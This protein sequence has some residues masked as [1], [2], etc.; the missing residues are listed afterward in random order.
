L[1]KGVI[2]DLGETLMHLNVTWEQVREWR[3]QAIHNALTEQGADPS[4]AEIRRE[5]LQLHEEESDYAART[6]E[7]IEIQESFLKLFERLKVK[8]EQRPNMNE[9]V[10]RFFSLE[11]ESWVIFSGVPEMLQQ[12]R[13]LGLK[14]GLLSNAR[15]DWAVK[16]IMNRLS[17]TPYFDAILTSAALGIRKPRP[18]PF[19]EM[20]KLLGVGATEAVMVGNSVEAD[21]AGARPLGIRSIRVK[22]GDHPD[23]LPLQLE[24]SVDPDATA[25]AVDDIVPA[26]K[27]M[28]TIG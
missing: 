3:I 9:L 24:T 12:V 17:L 20:L 13:D 23:E 5:W 1:L 22:F 14:M 18:E 10:K 25:F 15:N 8:P 21:I 28:T 2:F 4:P 16:E 19:R 6:F 27:Q 11:A 26:I 7:E